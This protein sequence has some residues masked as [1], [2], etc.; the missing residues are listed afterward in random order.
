MSDISKYHFFWSGTFSQW[1]RS[2]FVLAD[3]SFQTAE[4]AMMYEKAMLFGD[5]EI[6]AQILAETDPGRQK[7]LGRRV[8]NFDDAIWDT[9][10]AR[11]VTEITRAKYGQNKGLRRKLF[12][13]IPLKLAEASP[14][15]T[16]WGIGLDATNAAITPPDLWP[17]KNLPGQILTAVRD[18]LADEYPEEAR[19]CAAEPMEQQND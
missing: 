15:D 13:T 2:D 6:A 16:I 7:A 14:V 12:Q 17:G 19:A 1:H 4:Q 10:K 8:R 11:I 9:Q 5:V 3:K 18:E